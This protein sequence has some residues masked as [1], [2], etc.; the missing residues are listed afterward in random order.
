[1]PPS[2]VSP[3]ASGGIVFMNNLYPADIFIQEQ[4]MTVENCPA[5]LGLPFL[6]LAV[7]GFSSNIMSSLSRPCKGTGLLVVSGLKR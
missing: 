1:M 6:P 2:T 3:G 7:S 4:Q 5:V